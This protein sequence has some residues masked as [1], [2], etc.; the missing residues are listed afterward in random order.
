MLIDDA[1][2]GQP[3]AFGGPI[4]APVMTRVGDDGLRFNRF[5]VTA[6]CSPTRA[7][8]LTGRN[9]HAVGFG[10]IGELSSG[11][12]GYT[13]FVPEDSAPFPKVLQG[14]GVVDRG[15]VDK[16]PFAFTGTVKKVVFDI[17]PH[18]SADDGQALHESAHHGHVARGISG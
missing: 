5:H 9:H 8:L 6:L 3:S 4:E 12:P 10:S 11:F 15:Y 16:A 14:N 1:G 18:L 2:F 17:K 7:A 13:A